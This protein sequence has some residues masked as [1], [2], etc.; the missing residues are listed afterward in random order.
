MKKHFINYA[1][2]NFFDAQRF[3]AKSALEIGGFDT[4]HCFNPSHIDSQFYSKHQAILNQPRG[5]GYWLWKPYVIRKTMDL[6]DDGDLIMYC[7]SASHFIRSAQPL[8]ELFSKYQQDLIPFD[9]HL[10]E[11]QWTKRDAFITL[12]CDTEEYSNSSQRLASFILLKKSVFSK[13]FIDTYLQYCCNPAILTDGENVL[14]K[15][16]YPDFQQHRHDQSIFSLLSKK[17][18]LPAYRDPSQ[19]GNSRIEQFQN[20]DYKQIIEHTRQK[21]P[22]QA[23]WYY[24]LKQFFKSL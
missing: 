13:K 17:F 16:N 18:G 19:W 21:S 11:H 6:V 15:P 22:K 7:D 23:K 3:G 20:S 5:A 12:D 10:S 4:A 2:P 14:G 9:L 1:T 24:P 8:F